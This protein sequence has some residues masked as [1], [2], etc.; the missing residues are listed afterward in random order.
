MSVLGLGLAA[1]LTCNMQ[2]KNCG[3]VT[4]Q[5]FCQCCDTE[6]SS[7]FVNVFDPLLSPAQVG[8][9]HSCPITEI[10]LDVG[11]QRVTLKHKLHNNW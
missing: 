4:K 6:D 3:V 2:E 1:A 10:Q 11:P 8:V 5:I 7:G 9:G